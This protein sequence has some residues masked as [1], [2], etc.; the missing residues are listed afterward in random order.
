MKSVITLVGALLVFAFLVMPGYSQITIN[1]NDLPFQVGYSW[2]EYSV[3]DTMGNGI[4]VNLGNTGGGNV[5][6]FNTTMYPN[7]KT[8]VTD[9]V[10]PATT[11]FDTVFS[12]ADFAFSIQEDSGSVFVYL[13]NTSTEL[14]GLGYGFVFSDTAV[15]VR[16]YPYE[17]FLVYPLTSG[18]SW[19]SDAVDTM[20][21]G[22][23]IYEVNRTV[24]DYLVDAWGTIE[25]PYGTFSCLRVRA[26]SRD[27]YNTYM[28]GTLV[29]SDSSVGV[30]YMW[31]GKN[32]GILAS[33][34]SQEGSTNPNFTL[35]S[36]VSFRVPASTGIHSENQLANRFELFQ[37][38]PNPFNPT[39]TIAFN[40]PRASEVTF[41]VYNIA[42]QLVE[43]RSLGQLSAGRHEIQFRA[44]R[45]PSGIYF[46]QIQA[47]SWKAVKRMVLMK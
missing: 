12:A 32:E 46:Y 40:I 17:T 11:P 1:S 5:W 43:Q 29:Y 41:S 47:G 34:D 37:N 3:S 7:G 26:T 14:Q 33:V 42:G 13:K 21:Y 44:N 28:G 18:T 30:S 20:W 35:A 9:V 45:L 22:S 2:T 31:F 16:R 6:T 24:V 23:G 10:D 39:T 27:Y 15:S 36:D 19:T 25:V 4:S 38:F 8:E